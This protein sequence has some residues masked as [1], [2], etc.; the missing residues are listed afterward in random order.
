MASIV[1][2][3][4]YIALAIPPAVL[5][6]P[7]DSLLPLAALALLPHSQPDAASAPGGAPRATTWSR[8]QRVAVMLV[9]ASGCVFNGMAETYAFI[10][11]G[12]MALG[13][14]LGIVAAG[15]TAW[16]LRRTAC[17]RALAGCA[18]AIALSTFVQGL[19]SLGNTGQAL[20]DLGF[21]SAFH[22]VVFAAEY[23]TL[24][25]A[26]CQADAPVGLEGNGMSWN[27]PPAAN[28]GIA[29]GTLIGMSVGNAA[30]ATMLSLALALVAAL[31]LGMQLGRDEVPARAA[32]GEPEN[33]VSASVRR[34]S[35][36]AGLSQREED[37]LVLWA[38]GHQIDYVA[39]QLC[40]SKNTAKTH[41]RHI[42]VKAGVT[43][44]EE[45]LRRL[46]RKG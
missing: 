10:L 7:L 37:V 11:P 34:L 21:G 26:L 24:A 28:L 19:M 4:T 8:R 39:E 14:A 18:L 33:A 42:Y 36:E 38:T 30:A 3:A 41:V 44:R 23:V 2:V 29:A 5:R 16:R 1:A 35:E 6:Q 32:S 15:L 27:G 40:I 45:L 31:L 17:G 46:E 9:L 20:L 12:T 43:S 22:V 13:S 25:V